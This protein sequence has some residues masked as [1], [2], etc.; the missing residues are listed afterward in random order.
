MQ[1]EFLKDK[2]NYT[3]RLLHSDIEARG[4]I[5]A[6]NKPEDVWCLV[7]R[8]DE[9]DEV[10][11]FHDYPEYD[12]QEVFDQGETH[13][14]PPRTG[15]LLDGVRFWYLAGKNGSKLSIHNCYSYDKPLLEKIWPKCEIPDEAWVD[16]FIQ[17]KI[18]YFDRP[19]RKGA[20]SAHGLL[21][22]SLMEGNKKPEV[23]DFSIMNAFMLHRCIIDT[24]TQKFAYNYLKKERDML[25]SKLG[26]DMEDAYEMEVEYTKTCHEQEQYGAKVDVPHIKRCIEYLDKTTA[27]LAKDITPKLPPTVKVSGGKVSRVEMAALFGYDT[28]SMKDEMEL[29][30]KDGEMVNQPVKP[31]YKPT[32]NFHIVQKVNVYSAFHIE[33]GFSK[34]FT[35]KNELTKWIKST[36][37]LGDKAKPKDYTAYMKEWDIDKTVEETK[38]LNKNTCDYFELNPEDTDIIVGAHTKIKFVES[39]LTQHE[40]VKGY[41]IKEGIRFAEEWNLKKDGEGQILKAEFDTEIRYPPKAR[42]DQQMVMKIKKGDAL[43]TSPKFG[44]KEYDQL[45]SEDGKNVGKYNTLV[46]RRRYLENYKD[47]D[48]KGLLAYVRPDGRVGA[49]VNNFNTATG[50]ASHRIIVN[51]PADGAVFGKEMRQ[52]IIADEGKELVGIDQKSSQLSICAFV[53][54]NTDYYNAVA[55]GVEFENEQD[56]STTY[57]G[58]SAHCVNSRYFN[59][60]TKSEWEEAVRTQNP[61]LIHE[62]VLKR[63]KSKGLSFASLF[64]CGPA[65]LAVMGGF[66]V[67]EAKTKLQAFLDNMGLSEVI[68]FLEKC[69][70]KYKRGKGF[71]IPTGFGYWVYCGG[72]HKAVNYLIQSLEGVVQKK[73]V[74]IMK[75]MFIAKGYWGKSVNKILD[76][77]KYCA[78]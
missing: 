59:L 19:Q 52:S 36:H 35:K 72:M 40:V 47:P 66:E 23:E 12:N 1:A 67:P 33:Q 62:I 20:K 25:L 39:S 26:I 7:S 17:S 6:V 8:D 73:A 68:K 63:K 69:K 28:S 41:L 65:K 64:G 10:F 27:E 50:R 2:S 31:Y 38:L 13:I 24:K 42:P 57:H 16:T 15:T 18:Q 77:H 29:V 4:F 32:T 74:E 30:K 70:D 34:K 78:F 56:G 60:V 43:L 9:T 37:P 21:N 14:I 45:E 48:N 49:G 53:T 54:N 51:L 61:N 44:E 76:M 75:Q 55:T 11:L 22:Y 3:N 5:D 58:S 71:Y 46:H